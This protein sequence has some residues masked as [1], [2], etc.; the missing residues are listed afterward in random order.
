MPTS[1]TTQ[2][3]IVEVL[4]DLK[5]RLGTTMLYVTHDLA[6][7]S[8]ISDRVAV[9]YAGHIVETAPVARLF[10]EPL[11]PYTRGLIASVPGIEAA[12][13]VL[14]GIPLRGMLRRDELP[15]GCPFAP[16]CHY[17]GENCARHRQVPETVHAD[18]LVACE[19]WHDIAG[20]RTVESRP[21][22][23][24]GTP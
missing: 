22:A 10:S 24:P 21:A 1:V 12:G 14:S 13:N 9:M 23:R 19:R 5:T 18:H 11:H 20:I 8:Q 2:E 17:V 7:L 6:L 4:R 15:P 16:R 3:Q